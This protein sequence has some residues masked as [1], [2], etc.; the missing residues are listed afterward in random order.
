MKKL[1]TVISVA[2]IKSYFQV[3]PDTDQFAFTAD[4]YAWKAEDSGKM[5]A[6]VATLKD[7]DVVIITRTEAESLKDE[8]ACGGTEETS[9][10]GSSNG[11]YN[12]TAKRE[13]YA[14]LTKAALSQL[15]TDRGITF[16]PAS[17]K[18]ALIDALVKAD[19]A[20]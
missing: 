14:K 4:G 8:K 15:L 16:D 6:H 9:G 20:A 1:L 18:D 2:T 12:E 10:G 7:Q 19:Q 17:L 13:E 11:G 5:Q 3:H